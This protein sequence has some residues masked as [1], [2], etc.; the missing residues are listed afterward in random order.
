MGY[1]LY[2]YKSK[3]QSSS[4]PSRYTSSTIEVLVLNYVDI[5]KLSSPVFIVH[6][7]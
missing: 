4:L 7:K 6:D 2:N 1:L 3:H 5:Y